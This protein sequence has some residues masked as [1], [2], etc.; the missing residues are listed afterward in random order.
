MLRILIFFL[1]TCLQKLARVTHRA[2]KLLVSPLLGQR[3]RFEPFCSDY[4]LEAIEVHGFG[5]L[6]LAAKRLLRCHP[7]C[8]GGLDPVPKKC[9]P[10][11]DTCPNKSKFSF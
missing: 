7:F 9:A 5:G 4:A 8:N 10:S 1:R 3:C 6:L 11:N 2:Y